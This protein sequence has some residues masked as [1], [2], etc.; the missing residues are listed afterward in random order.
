MAAATTLLTA[1]ANAV[2]CAD[3]ERRFDQ[4]LDRVEKSADYAEAGFAAVQ[5]LRDLQ[6]I[7][8]FEAAYIFQSI[9]EVLA[10]G[11]EDADAMAKA[12]LQEHVDAFSDTVEAQ[13]RAEALSRRRRLELEAEFLRARGEETLAAM[14]LDTPDEHAAFCAEGVISL[15]DGKESPDEGIRAHP[16]ARA[17]GLIG[18]RIAALA[19]TETGAEAYARWMALSQALSQ[20]DP[21]SGVSAVQ[22]LRDIGVLSFEE[23]VGL[24]DD[25]VSGLA[26]RHVEADRDCMRWEREMFELRKAAGL[27][28]HTSFPP[29]EEPFELRA[30][31]AR[32]DRRSH[33]IL[34]V[35][36]RRYGEH[37][38]ANLLIANP[39][40][41]HRIASR[42]SVGAW[43]GN[44]SGA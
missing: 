33:R 5:A 28:D 26:E 35:C 44:G 9:Y 30:L 39:A 27:D 34:A 20:D 2:T 17:T 42:V 1:A 24:V 23:S 25:I 31:A 43:G 18:E 40:E 41:Y 29:G 3:A 32:L 13:E 6:E 36:L 4:F 21:A 19:A 15:I 16:D 37:R 11:I 7:Q 12:L 14:L 8:P 38:M 10:E 22:A